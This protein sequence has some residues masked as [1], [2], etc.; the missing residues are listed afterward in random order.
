MCDC[1][2]VSGLNRIRP[3]LRRVSAGYR[4]KYFASFFQHSNR[5]QIGSSVTGVVFGFLLFL[6]R[7]GIVFDIRVTPALS[8]EQVSASS[9]ALHLPV[10]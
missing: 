3:V 6:Y 1:C 4:P 8:Q 5:S 7:M 2:V 10:S 9:V